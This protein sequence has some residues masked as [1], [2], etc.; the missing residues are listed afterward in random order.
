MNDKRQGGDRRRLPRGG[1]RPE[2]VRG[3]TPLVMV[4]DSEARRRDISEAILAKLMF[5]VAPVESAEKAVA[6]LRAL[7]PEVIVAGE[8]DAKKIRELAP[9]D[10]GIAIISVAEDTRVS[11]ALIDAVRQSLRQ[12]SHARL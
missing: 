7:N 12:R 11:E 9:L 2:D 10:N 5:A 3:F 6:I 1:R 4:V 8:E